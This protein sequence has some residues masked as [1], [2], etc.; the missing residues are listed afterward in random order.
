MATFSRTQAATRTGKGGSVVAEGVDAIVAA[1]LRE[2][3][4]VEG[5]ADKV[6]VESAAEAANMMR[7]LAPTRSN[8]LRD[9]ITADDKATKGDGGV[10]ADAGPTAF[11]A[12]FQEEGTVHH[13]P[14]P[15]AG[16][17]ADKVLPKFEQAIKN[18]SKL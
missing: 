10:Y 8:D 14:Q 11:H 17:T 2:A 16:P 18:L 7:D 6:V 3:A 15:F 13:A 12:R 5:R 1:F 9:S 4:E